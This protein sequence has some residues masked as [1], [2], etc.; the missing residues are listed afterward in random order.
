M[1]HDWQVGNFPRTT[2]RWLYEAL[3]N[4]YQNL[5]SVV[6]QYVCTTLLIIALLGYFNT[7]IL[8]NLSFHSLRNH[9]W[10]GGG[11]TGWYEGSGKYFISN[12]M[13]CQRIS[14]I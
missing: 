3:V 4:Y 1:Y 8:L 5:F 13:C 10:L 6:N 2:E 12:E 11:G 9:F 7:K 14:C